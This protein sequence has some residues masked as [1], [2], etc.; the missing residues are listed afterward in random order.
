MQKRPANNGA[1]T[2]LFGL[3]DTVRS[4]LGGSHRS[5]TFLQKSTYHELLGDQ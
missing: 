4:L 2:C 1:K 5:K 3:I